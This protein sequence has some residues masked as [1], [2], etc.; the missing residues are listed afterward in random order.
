MDA[1]QLRPIY[2]RDFGYGQREEVEDYRPGGLHPVHLGDLLGNEGRYRIVHK[3]GNGGFGL[4]W[5]CRDTVENKW[6][7]L[8]ILQAQDSTEDCA[9]FK[10]CK[11]SDE[12][13]PEEKQLH[14]SHIA[15]PTDYFWLDGPNGRHLCVVMP[16]LGPNIVGAARKYEYQEQPLKNICRQLVSAMAYLHKNDVCHGDFRSHNVCYTAESLDDASEEDILKAYGRPKLLCIVDGDDY[17][18]EDDSSESDDGDS[19]NV[20]DQNSQGQDLEDICESDDNDGSQADDEQQQLD[21]PQSEDSEQDDV[22][23]SDDDPEIDGDSG[24][25]EVD[26]EGT[27]HCPRYLVVNAYLDSA[28]KYISDNVAVIDFGESFLNSESRDSTGIPCGYRSPE[29]FFDGCGDLGFASDVWALGCTLFEV[30]QG[31]CPFGNGDVWSL[32]PHWE[33]LSG[34]MPEPFRSSLADDA[35]V[36]PEDPQQWVS[37]VQEERDDWTRQHRLP[38]GI[39]SALLCS[40][41]TEIQYVVPL[42]EGEESP[43]QQGYGIWCEPGNKVLSVSISQKEISL[44]FDLAKRIFSWAPQDRLQAA[45]I[46]QHDWLQDM[47]TSSEIPTTEALVEDRGDVPKQAKASEGTIELMDA[48]MPQLAL[49]NTNDSIMAMAWREGLP[50]MFPTFFRALRRLCG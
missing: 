8:K 39:S 38:S 1:Q 17:E 20:S 29:G 35:E 6:R 27:E 43:P 50:S 49:Q 24:Q 5:L 22:S 26:Y 36:V 46:L 3:L 41:S 23:M 14:N 16:L 47:N 44:L 32:M 45:H 4:V 19:D 42:A 28:S 25:G 12:M 9:D 10:I 7:A 48:T 2:V 21:V 30:R 13:D 33:D 15:F 18:W 40:L 11:M 31:A 37:V 34:P